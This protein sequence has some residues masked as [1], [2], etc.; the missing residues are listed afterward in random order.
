MPINTT[1]DPKP[2]QLFMKNGNSSRWIIHWSVKVSITYLEHYHA[3]LGVVV[4]A[5]NQDST[6]VKGTTLE[7]NEALETQIHS[8]MV[9]CKE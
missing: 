3:G 1:M 7:V 2:I 9:I 4:K 8:H 6:L 5:V